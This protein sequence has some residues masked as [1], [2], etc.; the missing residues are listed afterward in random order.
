MFPQ[1]LQLLLNNNDWGGIE[2]YINTL[3]K[4]LSQ[5]IKECLA[6]S[7]SRQEKYNEAIV[8]YDELLCEQPNNAKFKKF[9]KGDADL[10]QWVK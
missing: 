4:P 1:D 7:Y 10:P 2:N 5:D 8:I 3:Q 6:W 9:V